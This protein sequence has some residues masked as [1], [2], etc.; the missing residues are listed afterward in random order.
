MFN[1]ATSDD[2]DEIIQPLQQQVGGIATLHGHTGIHHIRGCEAKMDEARGLANGFT[3]G[4]EEGDHIVICFL[5]DFQHAFNTASG[6]ANGFHGIGGNTTSSGPGF[7][8]S[9][10]HGQPLLDLV[11]LLPDRSHFWAGVSLDHVLLRD[12]NLEP[13]TKVYAPPV[14]HIPSIRPIVKLA[15]LFPSLLLFVPTGH[16]RVDSEHTAPGPDTDESQVDEVGI[17]RN[18]RRMIPRPH[19][20]NEL[21]KPGWQ[22]PDKSLSTCIGH[23]PTP[24]EIP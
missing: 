1:S 5:L 2:L 12:W 20:R 18:I 11:I 16:Q 15:V 17:Y 9:D 10:L 14:L 7:A 21:V 23:C 3:G 6:A 24:L 8:H 4:P 19:G 22:L 13:V